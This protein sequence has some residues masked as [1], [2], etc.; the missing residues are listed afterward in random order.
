[1]QLKTLARTIVYNPET[2]KV[3]LVKNNGTS[4][5]YAPG[6]GWEYDHETI[7]ECAKRE[8]KE[9]T[10]LEVEVQRLLY[11]QEFHESADSIFFETFWLAYPSG[12]SE[13]DNNHVDLDPNG[14]VETARWFSREE[15]KDLTV[16]PKRLKDSFW[17][18]LPLSGED[19]FLGVNG[20]L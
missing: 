13:Y 20:S 11:V 18:Q 6:G 3:L 17:E 7:L 4:F 15:L 2:N 10:G 8:V 19:A 5:W 1:M 9:E 12:D 14:N 16:F